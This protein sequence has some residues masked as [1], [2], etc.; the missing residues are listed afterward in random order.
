ML[1]AAVSAYTTRSASSLIFIC[2]RDAFAPEDV[3][4]E[5]RAELPHVGVELEQVAAFLDEIRPVR[6]QIGV[7]ADAPA[8]LPDPVGHSLKP[9]MRSVSP[10]ASVAG[11]EA[12]LSTGIY[13]FSHF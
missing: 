2:K 9:S 8:T 12:R 5:I 6:L 11:N 10:A 7:V 4:D 3:R 1:F 13:A